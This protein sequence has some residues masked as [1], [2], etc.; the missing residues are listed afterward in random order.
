MLTAWRLSAVTGN[1]L[2]L[3]GKYEFEVRILGRTFFRPFLV[4]IGMTKTKAILGYDFIRE[5]QLVISCDHVFFSSA[6]NQKDNWECSVLVAT[7]DFKIAFR[8]VLHVP[9]GVRSTRG[10]PVPPGTCFVSGQAHDELG[11]W[12]S[13]SK[14]D[15]QGKGFSV[16]FNATYFNRTIGKRM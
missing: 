16:V 5:A 14:V 9:V 4:V 7:E 3:V 8:S 15:N 10:G 11:I 12:D 6:L 13:L 1:K 2:E